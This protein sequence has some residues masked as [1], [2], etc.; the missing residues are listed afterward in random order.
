MLS[1]YYVDLRLIPSDPQAFQSVI[2]MYQS[3]VEP[4][5]IK[6]VQRLAGIPI[7]GIAYSAVLAYNLS[8]PF[9]CVRRELK[10][11]GS[12]RRVEGLLQPGDNVLVLDDVTTSGKNIVEAAE[13]IRAE[14]GVVKDAVVLLD[15]QQGGGKALRKAGIRLHAF[16]T[17]RRIADKLLSLGTIDERQHKEI[18]SQIV[19]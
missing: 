6:R 16:T 14:G 2:A 15:R 4:A 3:I 18:L 13:A 8:K 11:H 10:G 19:S 1:P 9:L 7:A 12:E 17:M 5:L